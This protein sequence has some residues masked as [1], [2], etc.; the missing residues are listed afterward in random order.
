MTFLEVKLSDR[1]QAGFSGGP[2]WQTLVVPMAN[3]RDRRRQDWS[4]P[5]HK[6]T[7]DYTTLDPASQNEI[8]AAFVAARGQMHAFGF[9]DWNDFK[10]RGQQIGL[11]DGTAKPLQLSKNYSFGIANYTRAITLPLLR[12]VRVYQAG[13]PVACDVDQLT[14]LVTPHAPW[15]AGAPIT[16]DFDFLV[17]VRFAKDYFPFT[18]NSMASA[19]ATVELVEDF[20]Q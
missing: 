3:G 8:L 5:K 16:A 12:T 10:A 7:A 1:V 14:G 13:L 6:Y 9:K 18:R 19:Q 11:G 2:E 17:R 20:G 15:A 4:M